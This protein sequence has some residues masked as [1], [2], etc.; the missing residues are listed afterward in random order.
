MAGHAAHC[1]R[2]S[3]DSLS[4]QDMDREWG[5]KTCQ[6]LVWLW[7]NGLWGN[8]KCSPQLAKSSG[9]QDREITGV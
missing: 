8:G 4:G 3:Q 7:N 9:P 1:G 6:S 5:G 2:D